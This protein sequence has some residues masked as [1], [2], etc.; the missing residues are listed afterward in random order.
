MHSRVSYSSKKTVDSCK[1]VF[2]YIFQQK[3]SLPIVIVEIIDLIHYG[4]NS[5]S[6][7]VM[8]KLL[9]FSQNLT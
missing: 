2:E 9:T 6:R 8:D 4:H 7:T 5:Q 1:I 3:L